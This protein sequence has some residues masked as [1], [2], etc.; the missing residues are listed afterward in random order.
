MN[1]AQCFGSSP[2]DGPQRRSRTDSVLHRES[3]S[4]SPRRYF[5]TVLEGLNAE[6]VTLSQ[7]GTVGSEGRAN[8]IVNDNVTY[9]L[10][11]K[12]RVNEETAT[13]TITVERPETRVV[14][15]FATPT[16]IA[17]G[18]TSTIAYLTENATG[19]S[20][21]PGIGFVQAAVKSSVP[22]PRRPHIV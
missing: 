12:N 16:N 22:Q 9:R 8:V 6:E 3:D 15:C 2:G 13:V 1:P 7:I 18:E 17:P 14:S 4:S 21:S 20:I 5:G 11:A 19:V 10:T